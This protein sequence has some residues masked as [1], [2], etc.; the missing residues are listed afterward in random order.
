MPDFGEKTQIAITLV[1]MSKLQDCEWSS[2]I[3]I[4][5][6]KEGCV[7]VGQRIASRKDVVESEEVALI[8]LIRQKRQIVSANF[9][10]EGLLIRWL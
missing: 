9:I 4:Q 2:H 6:S 1:H 3:H 8:L 10:L 7:S 5:I